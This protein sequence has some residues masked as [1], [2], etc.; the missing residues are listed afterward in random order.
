MVSRAGESPAFFKV[1]YSITAKDLPRAH[2]C[3]ETA[4]KRPSTR[5]VLREERGQASA[6][7]F[8]FGLLRNFAVNFWLRAKHSLALEA[9]LWC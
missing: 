8:F 9:A 7:F 3:L 6:K 4:K 1:F 5:R 2:K